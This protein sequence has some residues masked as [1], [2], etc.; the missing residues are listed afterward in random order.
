M[1]N[2]ALFLD[3]DGTLIEHV[4]YLHHI[5]DVKLQM[6]V[7]TFVRTYQDRGYLPIIITNQSGVARGMFDEETVQRVNAHVCKLLAAEGITIAACYYCPHHQ[8]KAT[9]PAYAVTC[10]CRKP[11]AG[12]LLKAATDF[13]IDLNQSI[14]LGDSQCDWDAGRAAGCQIIDVAA[15]QADHLLLQTT[16][17][18]ND[19]TQAR[20]D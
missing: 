5:E 15:L 1:K 12:M 6:P 11:Q 3:R 13:D 17:G 16:T 9:I 7:I 10:T 19:S 20:I 2:K 18:T 4:P 8:T 14:M